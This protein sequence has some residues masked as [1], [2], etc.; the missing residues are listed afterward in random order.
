V[1]CNVEF[2]GHL[3]SDQDS[4]TISSTGMGTGG[5]WIEK[6]FSLISSADVNRTAEFHFTQYEPTVLNN[7]LSVPRENSASLNVFGR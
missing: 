4:L 2:T 6:T 7:L 1:W 3:L 5:N